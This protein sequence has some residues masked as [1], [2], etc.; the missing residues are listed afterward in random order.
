MLE[1]I[2]VCKYKFILGSSIIGKI[3]M[4]NLLTDMNKSENTSPVEQNN[5]FIFLTPLIYEMQHFSS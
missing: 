2:C 5:A 4:T 1:C 3:F